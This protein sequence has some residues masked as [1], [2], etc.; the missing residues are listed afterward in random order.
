MKHLIW[1]PGPFFSFLWIDLTS[2]SN[3]IQQQKSRQEKYIHI[4][5][6]PVVGELLWLM[7]LFRRGCY[8]H[9]FSGTRFPSFFWKPKYDKEQ[10][11]TT[12]GAHPDT[13]K[14]WMSN[15]ALYWYGVG[16]RFLIYDH[17]NHVTSNTLTVLEGD[18]VSPVGC[19]GYRSWIIDEVWQLIAN[20]DSNSMNQ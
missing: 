9:H 7:C 10:C 8:S 14:I 19:W 12:G 18:H 4:I 2:R 11:G 17:R 6:W 13:S 20:L 1:S 15:E 3:M 16:T 5:V